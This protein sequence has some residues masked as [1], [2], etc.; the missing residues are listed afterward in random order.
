M[1]PK[2]YLKI[3]SEQT[4]IIE[5]AENVMYLARIEADKSP[6]PKDE[7]RRA[8]ADDI[9]KGLIV[10]QDCGNDE[11]VWHIVAELGYY[12]DDFKAYVADDG[13]RYGLNGA[14]V[15]K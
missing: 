4:A 12:G 1:T 8:V 15:Y 7:L 11:W 3:E 6:P 2:E 9:R 14:W 5:A 10:W 13:S